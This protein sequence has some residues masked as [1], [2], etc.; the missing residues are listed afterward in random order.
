[1]LCQ[2]KT[3]ENA[4]RESNNATTGLFIDPLLIARIL[5]FLNIIAILLITKII[6][7]NCAVE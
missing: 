5:I 1:L 6:Y 7:E 3:K 2:Q 4:C